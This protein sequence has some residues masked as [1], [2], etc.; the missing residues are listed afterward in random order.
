M[1]GKTTKKRAVENQRPI[2]LAGL[3]G[4]ADATLVLNGMPRL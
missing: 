2:D 1:S 4:S 3:R